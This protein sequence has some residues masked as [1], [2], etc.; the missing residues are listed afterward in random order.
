M[1]TKEIALAFLIFVGVYL[2]ADEDQLQSV[3]VVAQ[4]SPPTLA[5]V[6]R[7]EQRTSPGD[8]RGTVRL[9][10][11]IVGVMMSIAPHEQFELVT[12]PPVI[13][14]STPLHK[15][16]DSDL[17]LELCRSRSMIS[18]SFDGT[19]ITREEFLIPLNKIWQGST[20]A[21]SIVV[22]AVI[23]GNSNHQ[24]DVLSTALSR[25]S[26]MAGGAETLS[27]ACTRTPW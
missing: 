26:V 23:T 15:V 6:P 17:I 18:K 16:S 9:P 27:D 13:P 2:R 22:Q 14:G 10:P 7:S 24:S 12:P 11:C 25:D 20:L 3:E 21:Q 1:T 4:H 5:C 19:D 8:Y